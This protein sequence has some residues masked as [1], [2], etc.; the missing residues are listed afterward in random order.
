MNELNVKLSP[1][2][3]LNMSFNINTQGYNPKEVDSYLDDIIGDYNEFLRVI[4][5]LERDRNDL[6]EDNNRLR[7]ELHKLKMEFDTISEESDTG[8]FTSNNVDLL[9]RLSN[10]EKIVYGKNE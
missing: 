6:I 2:E 10:L 3:I 9:K 7:N 1:K 8:K 5:K 4:R